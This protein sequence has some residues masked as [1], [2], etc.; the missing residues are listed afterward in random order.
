MSKP[1]RPTSLV[2]LLLA[3]TL[4]LAGCSSSTATSTAT[5]DPG[6]TN[7]GVAFPVTV[8]TAYGKVTVE[9]KPQRIVVLVPE[10]LG[11]LALVGEKNVVTGG[12]PSDLD[13]MPWLT[14][15]G[16][17]DAKL[18]TADYSTSVEAVAAQKPDLILTNV[19]GSDAKEYK[20]LS[21]IAPTYVGR[22]TQDEG[23][24]NTW[25]ESLAD[26]VALTGHDPKILS[27]AEADYAATLKAAADKLPGLQGKTFQLGVLS[28]EDQQLWLTEYANDPITGLGLRLGEGQ[29]SGKD[30][31]V[32]AK[33]P[34]YSM[35]NI[36]KLNADVVFIVTHQYAD[37]DGKFLASLKKDPRVPELPAAKNGTLVYLYG[38]QWGAVQEPTP[39]SVKWW[40]GQVLP[41]LEKSALNQ[42][43]Q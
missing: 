24:A 21:Q 14:Y 9:K 1:L 38:P 2:A 34:K 16:E 25:R 22:Y 37:P 26:V 7:Q 17:F 12:A 35:E 10:F 36:D 31:S 39:A 3:L 13:D 33:A 32:A 27:D 29:P 42:S 6:S 28:R 40:L 4:A 30:G 15:E 8:D 23:G 18:F 19:W 43:G 41:Q 5:A 20:Q 11:H